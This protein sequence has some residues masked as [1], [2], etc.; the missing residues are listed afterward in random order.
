MTA[1][2]TLPVFGPDQ[3]TDQ[4]DTLAVFGPTTT[5]EEQAVAVFSPVAVNQTES[6]AVF[7]IDPKVDLDSL[8]VFIPSVFSTDPPMPPAEWTIATAAHS[9]PKI[10][11]QREIDKIIRSFLKRIKAKDIR[12]R[13]I[14]YTTY[15]WLHE[16]EPVPSDTASDVRWEIKLAAQQIHMGINDIKPFFR[17]VSGPFDVAKLVDV[18][19][20][21]LDE[22]DRDAGE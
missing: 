20:E 9:A 16:Q 8:P 3:K 4:S 19:R 5:P 18:R 13:R 21:L 15:T 2:R 17:V 14:G 22:M 7:S 12:F 11:S 6:V 1:R 10:Q